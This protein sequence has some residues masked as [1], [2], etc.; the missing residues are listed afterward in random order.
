LP[1]D[2]FAPVVPRPPLL[3]R[4]AIL[5]LCFF[6]ASA[7]LCL[8]AYLAFAADGP[9][10]GGAVSKRWSPEDF[11]VQRGTMRQAKDG[12]WVVSPDESG[13]AVIALDTTFRSRDYPVIA[14]RV[15]NL[16]E[17]VDAAMLW[18]SDYRAS[19][20]STRPLPVE[21]GRTMPIDL[22]NDRNWIGNIRGLAL[23][24]RNARG[25]PVIIGD[26]VAKAMTPAEILQD[27][28][29]EWLEFEP[30][31][32]ASINSVTGGAA[33]QD[34]PLPVLLAVIVLAAALAYAGLARWLSGVGPFRPAVVAAIFIA[35][36]FLLDARWQ[37]NLLRQ[38]QVTFEQYAGKS[39][40]E[41]HL[42]AEDGELFAFIEKARAKLPSLAEPAPRVF[43]VADVHY[44][45]GR[46]AYHLYP[47][48]VFF[49]PLQN[50]MP[51]T[52]WLRPGDYLLAY[53]ES[54][55]QYDGAQR[56]LRWDGGAPVA[57]ELVLSEPNAA[58]FRVL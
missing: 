23:V 41:R 21:A 46:G 16:P 24:L 11:K 9:W 22:T 40:Q 17:N 29:R 52:S 47:Y 57:A 19:R 31:N 51:A 8:A 5:A 53:R 56:S 2:T 30:W 25:Q 28:V 4:A 48:N 37:W 55:V 27:R 13:T 14:W 42:A 20:M 6:A 44:L 32:G 15:T 38:L 33:T 49:D 34:L 26:V 7:V 54:S 3:T 58:L 12:S 45:R 39:W 10:R 36:W 35:G 1:S 50:T 18:Y 43:V